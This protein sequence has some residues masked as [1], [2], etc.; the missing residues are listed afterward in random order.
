MANYRAARALLGKGNSERVRER[1]QQRKKG[2]KKSAMVRKAPPAKWRRGE[3]SIVSSG[4]R[5][6]TQQ[7]KATPSP[8]SARSSKL[9]RRIPLR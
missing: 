9:A 5:W 1:G 6:D 7:T 4:P 2:T 3:V 8:A